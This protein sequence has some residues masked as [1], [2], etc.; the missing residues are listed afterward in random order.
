MNAKNHDVNQASFFVEARGKWDK[1]S[2][3]SVTLLRAI[4]SFHLLHPNKRE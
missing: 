4:D 2:D 1:S 3:S